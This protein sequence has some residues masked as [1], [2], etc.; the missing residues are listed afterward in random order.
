M[1]G[2]LLQEKLLNSWFRTNKDWS[3]LMIY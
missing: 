3:S 1:R 2:R